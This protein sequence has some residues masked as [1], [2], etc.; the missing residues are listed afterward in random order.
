VGFNGAALRGARRRSLVDA[1]GIAGRMLQWGR[2]PRSAETDVR[3]QVRADAHLLQWGRAPRSAETGE[4]LPVRALALELQ[5]GRAPRSAETHGRPSFG[6]LISS[7]SMGPR[8]EERGDGMAQGYGTTILC[9]LQWGRAPRSAE[10]R[11]MFFTVILPEAL[12]WG[13][14][15][16][17]A[18]TPQ[19]RRA[20]GRPDHASMGPRSE[21]RG[22]AVGSIPAPATNTLQ[23]GRAPRSAETRGS[24]G[25]PADDLHSFNG[26]ALRGARR[27][28][29]AG[30]GHRLAPGFNGAALRGARRRFRP[31]NSRTFFTCFNGAA[32]RGARRHP[33]AD[34]KCC[35]ACASMGPRSEERGDALR[36]AAS[37]RPRRCFNGA[38]LRGARRRCRLSCTSS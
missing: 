7:A 28:Q 23:W 2:A 11:P 6:S 19:T 34:P 1:D 14:A 5:W 16:R 26:A 9:E 4:G 33:K 35:P 10:T 8:S 24:A 22:D 37:A 32:L 3:L 15:P 12:Q 38:A 17:S 20:R 31:A 27:P 13:R 36:S 21:E 18:E 25:R 30:S 29:P